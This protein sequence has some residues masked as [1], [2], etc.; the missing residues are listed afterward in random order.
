M[1]NLIRNFFSKIKS[2][3]IICLLLGCI[4]QKGGDFLIFFIKIKKKLRIRC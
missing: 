1:H 4:I 3:L 2:N